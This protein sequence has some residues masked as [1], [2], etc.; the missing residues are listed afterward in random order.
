L[1]QEVGVR[2]HVVAEKRSYETHKRRILAGLSE[3]QREWQSA[4]DA[5]LVVSQ[6]PPYFSYTTDNPKWSRTRRPAA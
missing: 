4:A 3:A 1:L 2:S 5:R 6:T